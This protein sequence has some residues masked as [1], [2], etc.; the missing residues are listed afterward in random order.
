[1]FSVLGPPECQLLFGYFL[2]SCLIYCVPYPIHQGYTSRYR[3]YRGLYIVPRWVSGTGRGGSRILERGG[4]TNLMVYKQKGGPW[5][6]SNY[7]DQKRGVR[8]P[9][10]PPPGSAHVQ[11]RPCSRLSLSLISNRPNPGQQEISV[12][13]QVHAWYVITTCSI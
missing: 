13:W 5:R 12:K 8:A 4:G 11:V 1:M 9:W 3:V 6:G 2:F 10:T 7:R